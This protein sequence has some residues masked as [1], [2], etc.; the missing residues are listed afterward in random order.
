MFS[1][2]M[3][4]FST[5]D[6]WIP[7]DQIRQK[8]TQQKQSLVTSFHAPKK[9]HVFAE[10]SPGRSENKN[11][12]KKSMAPVTMSDQFITSFRLGN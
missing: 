6:D 12:T 4:G 8:I 7:W 10:L 3:V 1:L 11:L 5:W 9:G 2:K